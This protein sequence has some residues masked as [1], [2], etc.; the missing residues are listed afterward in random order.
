MT[1]K[2]ILSVVTPTRGNFSE[3]WLEQLL[4]IQGEVQFVLVFPPGTRYQSFADPRIKV[5]QSP[6]KGEMF[7]RFVGLLN[8]DGDYV[9]ALDDDDYLHPEVVAT[10]AA[11][12]QRF[13]DSIVLR[14]M[15]DKIDEQ[16]VEAY[17]RA[18]EPIPAVSNLSEG[19]RQA[20]QLQQLPIA[21]LDIPFDKRY[22]V[23]PF[24]ERRDDR[25]P[26]IENFNTKVWRND[27]VQK[28]LVEISQ[29]TILGGILTWIPRSG[30]DRLMGL[31]VQATC[32]E[33]GITVGHW[34]PRPAQ[35]RFI[36]QD[37]ALK[38]PR[39]H[40]LSDFLLVK[41][42]PQYGYFWNLFFN[43][44]SYL[45]RIVGKSL[46]WKLQ[47]KTYRTGTPAKEIT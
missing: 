20:G 1:A 44:V 38:P 7:Q 40:F 34:M 46:K 22:L 15:T 19:K 42:F 25:A 29:A 9:I 12:F 2:P 45:P 4:C 33:S 31:F 14:L 30:F 6:Y 11:Y 43:K 8:A 13:P 16:N 35:V 39:Y 24:I 47:K 10:V 3:Y 37:P 23:W 36:S 41:H 32:F 28:S 21:P 26:H 17:R 5:L 27:V 18:W